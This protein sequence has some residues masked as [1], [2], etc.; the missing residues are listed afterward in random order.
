VLGFFSLRFATG[1]ASSIGAVTT[2]LGATGTGRLAAGG[3]GLLGALGQVLAIVTAIELAR[4]IKGLVESGSDAVQDSLFGPG[5]SDATKQLHEQGVQQ[6]RSWLPSWLGGISSTGRPAPPA[7]VQNARARQA[8]DFFKSR[9][10]SD[11]A[12]AALTSR[13]QLESKFDPGAV[14]DSGQAYGALQWHPDRQAN[15]QRVMGKDIR[16]STYEEQLQFADWELHNT[17][18][19]AGQELAVPG[20]TPAQAGVVVSSRYVRPA[21]RAGEA[22]RTG[23]LAEQ[24]AK[25]YTAPQGAPA[26][27]NGAEP[28]IAGQVNVTVTHQNPPPGSRIIANGSGDVTVDP[29]RT[30][31]QALTSP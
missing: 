24:Y 18:R 14:G 3:A 27:I 23:T 26:A 17:E 9:G 7:D 22:M 16:N 8:F 31:H 6:F 5:S 28:S 29:P 15:F 30:E 21:D 19:A 12:S 4:G 2:A 13:F 1:M 10:W 11:A 25:Q 20:L